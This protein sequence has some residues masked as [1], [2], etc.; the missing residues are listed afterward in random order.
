M[1]PWPTAARLAAGSVGFLLLSH[2]GHWLSA[3]PG[4]VSSIRAA[5]TVDG[6]IG[7][8][9]VTSKPAPSPA[10]PEALGRVLL[11]RAP[12]PCAGT[13]TDRTRRPAHRASRAQR[14][15][16]PVKC[17]AQRR[18]RRRPRRRPAG[19]PPRPIP[20]HAGPIARTQVKPGARARRPGRSAPGSSRS[21][22]SRRFLRRRE[23][24][25]LLVQDVAV[26]LACA[27]AEH[28]V[29]DDEAAARTQ[30]S[31]RPG[32]QDPLVAVRQVMQRVAG[33]HEIDAGPG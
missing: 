14:V 6:T 15:H 1:W 27:A 4:E 28:H 32:Y 23:R 12:A 19:R 26:A 22:T 16:S 31:R 25:H 33:D 13:A 21:A 8:L 10:A 30:P 7:G 5:A 17:P 29:G 20:L 2:A 11:L 9:Q 24:R 18:G 3:A